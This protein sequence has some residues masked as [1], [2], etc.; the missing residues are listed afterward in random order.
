MGRLR[1]CGLSDADVQ[2]VCKLLNEFLEHVSL[3]TLSRYEAECAD[4]D[5][6]LIGSSHDGH[7][8]IVKV[9]NRWGIRNEDGQY[10]LLLNKL[11]GSISSCQRMLHLYQ[12]IQS[13]VLRKM[14]ESMKAGERP[15]FSLLE[16]QVFFLQPYEMVRSESIPQSSVYLYELV[17]IAWRLSAQLHSVNAKEFLNQGVGR[18]LRM[19]KVSAD[20]ISQ[21]Y[22]PERTQP[23]DDEESAILSQNI[24]FFYANV[25]AIVDCLAFV[26]AFEEPS[27]SLDRTH[28]PDLQKV[29]FFEPGFGQQIAAL[30]GW[31]ELT[32]AKVWY[33]TIVALRHPV[34]HR[35]PLYLPEIYADDDSRTAEEIERTY[36]VK[37]AAIA[38]DTTTSV[39]ETA[40]LL[41]VLD[42]ERQ[43]QRSRINVFS[44]V[45]LHSEAETKGWHHLSRLTLD[46]GILCYLLDS[47][48]DRL[49][50]QHGGPQSTAGTGGGVEK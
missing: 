43:Q 3:R 19:L 40:K 14:L 30:R 32:K 16:V 47:S 21:I 41:D 20:N 12:P 4:P 27:Y 36:H 10:W 8:D 38:K 31:P 50:A 37:F 48:F 33:D 46:L 2:D 18:R 26:F 23:L 17:I 5:R 49:A 15:T 11:V 35:I 22:S 29:R 34:A 45:F 9:I 44:G 39:D 1:Q 25:S 7:S 13:L 24:N 28:R 42:A 6:P